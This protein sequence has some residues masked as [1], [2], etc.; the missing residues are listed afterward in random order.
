M[1][2]EDHVQDELDR[3]GRN[4][5]ETGEQVAAVI[6][7]TG[8]IIGQAASGDNAISVSVSPGGMLRAVDIKPAVLGRHPD[9]VARE[10]VRLAAQATKIAN[11]RM[12]SSLRQVMSANAAKSLTELGMPDEPV[13]HDREDEEFGGVLS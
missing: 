7:R 9:E 12:H 5:A 3:L 6:G 13:P 1:G 4:V 10:V 2:N 8:P 11:S